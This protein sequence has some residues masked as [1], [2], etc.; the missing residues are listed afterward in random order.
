MVDVCM[1]GWWMLQ[2]KM[3]KDLK[4]IHVASWVSANR[5]TLNMLKTDFMVIP[6]Q[7]FYRDLAEIAEISPRSHH[8]FCWI[9]NLGEICSISPRLPRTRRDC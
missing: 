7:N 6:V 2:N 4:G 8:D 9:L 3:L 5:L 1:N